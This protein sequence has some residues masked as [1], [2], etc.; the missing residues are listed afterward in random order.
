VPEE[1]FYLRFGSFSNYLWLRKFLEQNGGRT[2]QLISLRGHDAMVNQ[3]TQDQ[4]GLKENALAQLLGNQLISDVA[5][6]GRDTYM[7][8]GA[9]IGILFEARNLALLNNE[10]LKQRRSKVTEFAEVGATLTDIAFG[11]ATM[12]AAVTPD[13]RLRSFQVSVDNYLLVTNSSAM[14]ERFLRLKEQGGAMAESTEFLH[15]RAAF[16]LNPNAT[17]FAYL[18]PAFFRGLVSPQYQIELRRRMQAVTDL[19]LA[20]LARLVALN[21]GL[22]HDSVESLMRSDLLPPNFLARADGSHAEL[23][24]DTA[25]DSRR[26]ARGSFLPI[27]DVP[28]EAV[29]PSEAASYAQIA[30]FHQSKWRE[31]DPLVVHVTREMVEAG[32]RERITIDAQMLPFNRDK[33]GTVTSV[34]GP[35]VPRKIR[36]PAGDAI[37]A[38]VVLQGGLLRPRVQP[39]HIFLG[40]QDAEVPITFSDRSLMRVLQILRSAP[41]YLGAWPEM[42]LLNMLPLARRPIPDGS[43]MS[44]LPFGLWHLQAANGFSLIGVDPNILAATA[45]QLAV[46]ETESAA[47]IHVHISDVS[48]SKIKTWFAALDFQRAYETS[49]GNTR[50]LHAFVEQLGVPRGDAL[51]AA[52]KVLGVDLVCTLGGEYQLYESRFGEAYWGST[53]WPEHRNDESSPGQFASPSLAWFRGLEAAVKLEED[54]VTAHAVLE[55]KPLDSDKPSLPFFN[56]F[57]R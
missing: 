9:A 27:P 53:N 30:Q 12:S 46:E 19:E 52:E 57:N 17:L 13:N 32:E 35:A 2:S 56:F 4:L 50:L 48:K 38:Q 34:I 44:Q 54:R 42:G 41:A 55:V 16:P 1:C 40:I 21:E 3:R 18:S 39:H 14:A 51:T 31:M 6:I 37:T 10:L 23:V 24:G 5:L 15:A 7:R 47:Q 22:P 25:R 45:P 26:G 36:Q 20:E 43:G 8:E 33:Y 11:D 49:V 28:I 29:T